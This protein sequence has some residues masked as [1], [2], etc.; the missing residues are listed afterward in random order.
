MPKRPPIL[1]VLVLFPLVASANDVVINAD[2]VLEIDGKKTFLIGFIMPPQPD[3]KTPD[4][5]NGIDELADAG[6]TFIRTGIIGPNSKWNDQAFSRER[7]WQDAAARNGMHCLVGVRYAGSV[8]PEKPE[9]EAALRNVVQTFKD[10]P[11]MGAYYGVDEP[12][13]TKH[14][15]EPM[16]RAY[17][18][19]RELD[20]RHPVWIC[21]APRGTVTSMRRYDRCGDATGGDIYPIS[22]PPGLHVAS[23]RPDV[24]D[25]L[26]DNRDISLAGDFTRMMLEVADAPPTKKPVWM[27]LQISWSGVNNPGK[28]L[29]FPTFHEQRFMTYQTII[30]GARGVIYFGGSN[31][32]SIA[33]EDKPLAWNWRFWRRV[34]RPVVEEIGT[35]SPLY[36]A[37]VAPPSKLPIKCDDPGI[38]FC[39][40]EANGS[41]FLLACRRDHKTAQA[42]FTGLPVRERSAEVMFESP[43]RA[44]V[45]AGALTDWF[46]PFEVHVYR[47]LRTE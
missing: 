4:G 27:C 35:K 3:A 42:T 46:A 30:A 32:N 39:V 11:G 17:R 1:L 22:Y 41:V 38:E 44:D 8:E 21:Q 19:I 13:W 29:R 28:T 31:S 15:V 16:E 10:H 26:R 6:A 24:P 18:I 43:R 7:A 14:A 20:P 36:P 45:K 25:V 2:R 37:L 23:T 47:V 12:D 5:R 40:R 33:E 9:N 34:L